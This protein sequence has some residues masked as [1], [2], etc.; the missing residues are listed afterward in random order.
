M[1][2]VCSVAIHKMKFCTVS[3]EFMFV[4]LNMDDHMVLAY[5]IMGLVISLC[6]C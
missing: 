4:S 6:V 2:D 1:S 3:M 5:S